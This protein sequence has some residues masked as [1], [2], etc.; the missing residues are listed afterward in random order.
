[1]DEKDS[2]DIYHDALKLAEKGKFQESLNLMNEVFIFHPE[3]AIAYKHYFRGLVE[4]N[5]DSR[6][7]DFERAKECF[8]FLLY[9]V[10]GKKEV[11]GM[12]D[13]HKT[14]M[15]HWE[16]L[17]G[18]RQSTIEEYDTRRGYGDIVQ[19]TKTVDAEE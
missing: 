10:D 11:T 19:L 3:G 18:A 12:P 4:P 14:M 15:D 9:S 17:E 5:M 13:I 8:K 6:M 7:R 2:Y 1:M 16:G